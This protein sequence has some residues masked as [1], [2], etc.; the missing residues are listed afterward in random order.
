[1]ETLFAPLQFILLGFFGLLGVLIVVVLLFGK[2]V[3]KRW[4]YEAEF[5]SPGGQEFG[6]FEIEISR[7][8]KDEPQYSFKARLRMRHESLEKGL[9]VHVYLDDL[10]V[11]RGNVDKAGRI[12]LRKCALREQAAN[13]EVGRI[14]RVVWGGIEQFRAPLKPD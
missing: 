8:E 2:R 1:M 14:C 3:T 4:E 12:H 10:L 5:R 11:M 13:P 6:E 7:I 9:M